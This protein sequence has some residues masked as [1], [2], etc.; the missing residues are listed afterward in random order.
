M[1]V[2]HLTWLLWI[3]GA[4]FLCWIF[5][6]SWCGKK[7]TAVQLLLEE[8][9][10]AVT[11]A[12]EKSQAQLE[13]CHTDEKHYLAKMS[14]TQA[15]HAVM[16][17]E[18]QL[19]SAQLKQQQELLLQ[20]QQELR[21]LEVDR[22]E[23]KTSLQ[24]QKVLHHKRLED[25]Q[26]A[27]DDLRR[28]FS[29]LA[30]KIFDER[31]Q[32]FMHNSQERLS[33][34]LDPFKE[35]IQAFEKRVDES[36]QQESRE[37]F[38]LGKELEKLQG[39][40][41]RLTDEATQLTRA[42]KGQKNQGNWGE[43]VL[44]RVL[45]SAGL[46]RGREYDTQV[47][48]KDAQN[49][50]FQPDVLI[51]LPDNK[52]V[53]VD[54]KVSLQAWQQAITTDDDLL[55]QQALKQHLS[56]VRQ[57]LK[58]LSAKDYQRLTDINSLDFVLL[59]IPIE[60]AFAGVLQTDPELFQEAFAKGVVIVSPTTLLATLQVVRGLWRQERQ[61]LNAREIA[62]TAGQLYDKFVA[63]VQDLDDVGQRIEQLEKAY[64]GARN[65]LIDGRGSLIKRAEKMR[66]LGARNS[67]H[68]PGTLTE[69]AATL[70]DE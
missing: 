40:N 59:F 47:Q 51:Y 20:Q 64:V 18:N 57:H 34:L 7:N 8:R 67:K 3:D 12:L 25:I 66:A 24:D 21:Q 6:F 35:R 58:D 46:M 70:G 55:R 14:S 2:E 27:R 1:N 33:Q 9:L 16:L 63:F 41:Q 13:G 32:R 29:E 56:S 65:K 42:L 23:L 52:Q 62:E 26:A 61:N 4:L 38:S 54:S 44:E 43:L 49:E 36:Y 31:E 60:A 19:L 11:Q 37:R 69:V 53:I 50:H 68:L 28:Q 5:W 30:R 39:L 45:E 48:L 15:E 17:R 22:A 10:L